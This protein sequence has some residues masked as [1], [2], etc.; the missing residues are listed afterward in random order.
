LK[1][2]AGEVGVRA[3]TICVEVFGGMGFTWE[4]DA[5]LWFKRAGFDRQVLGSPAQMR[6]RAAALTLAA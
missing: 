3:T 5:H 1:A 2:H 4:C 6:A